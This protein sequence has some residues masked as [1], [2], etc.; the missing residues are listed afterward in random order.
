VALTAKQQKFVDAFT[1]NATDAARKAGYAGND[2]TLAQVG[3]ENL[4]KPEVR[5]A[6]RA[7]SK[8]EL[9]ALVASR[10]ERQEFWT[11]LML[12]ESAS[13][14]DRLRASELLGR[15]EADFTEKVLVT[16][17]LTLEQLV[18]SAAKKPEGA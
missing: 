9:Q 17:K 5:E 14:A 18:E 2:A 3:Y 6:I 12:S 11:R 1:G 4:R 13:N 15:S 8:T 10:I 7:R 16:G